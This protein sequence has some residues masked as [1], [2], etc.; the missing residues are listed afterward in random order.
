[1]SIFY[2]S[3][4][5]LSELSPAQ[6]P[7]RLRPRRCPGDGPP[8]RRFVLRRVILKKDVTRNAAN[9]AHRQIACIKIAKLA[10]NRQIFRD[11]SIFSLSLYRLLLGLLV[12]PIRDIDMLYWGYWYA[13]LGLLEQT[14]P[15]AR[16]Y[17]PAAPAAPSARP[18]PRRQRL[19]AVRQ[20][21]EPAVSETRERRP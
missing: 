6:T 17:R 12:C 9:S 5:A 3:K 7:H 4:R 14:N 20:T 15:R 13:L 21:I 11:R 18:A 16:K 8:D 1:M 10:K 2:F 19:Q